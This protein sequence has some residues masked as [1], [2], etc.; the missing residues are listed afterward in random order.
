MSAIAYN[1]FFF[2]PCGSYNSAA[3]GAR[4]A[5]TLTTNASPFFGY[6]NV[7]EFSSFQG[8]GL[9][10]FPSVEVMVASFM[11]KSGFLWLR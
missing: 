1:A 4:A 9:D 7:F 11:L 6:F 5:Y 8:A 3:S 2:V 10:F